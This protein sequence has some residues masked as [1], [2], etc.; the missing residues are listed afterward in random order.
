MPFPWFWNFCEG[1]LEAQLSGHRHR[2]G[3]Q[4]RLLH[5]HSVIAVKPSHHHEQFFKLFC[6]HGPGPKV[7]GICCL[8]RRNQ[9]WRNIQSGK[10]ECYVQKGRTWLD[11]LIYFRQK[12]LLVQ[13]KLPELNNWDQNHGISSWREGSPKA[14]RNEWNCLLKRLW[15]EC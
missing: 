2:A 5:Q 10:A 13:E 11:L 14:Y 1:L 15:V 4:N 6:L 12:Y 7:L 3:F 8:Q 9:L